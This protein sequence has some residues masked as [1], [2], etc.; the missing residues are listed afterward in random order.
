MLRRGNKVATYLHSTAAS[1]IDL[2]RIAELLPAPVQPLPA[3]RGS[4]FDDHVELAVGVRGTQEAIRRGLDERETEGLPRHDKRRS[5][6]VRSLVGIAQRKRVA[7]GQTD[8]LGEYLEVVLARQAASR[9]ARGYLV[10]PLARRCLDGSQ[11]RPPERCE[12]DKGHRYQD[13]LSHALAF[14]QKGD[15][16]REILDLAP[17][18]H[19]RPQA[20]SRIDQENAG[21]V[22]H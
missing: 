1:E 5:E 10:E 17:E 16:V 11:R 15:I 6:H 8:G 22:R 3:R 4:G 19:H 2:G 21:G 7:D 20:A 13:G 9:S 14:Q 18:R 12:Q